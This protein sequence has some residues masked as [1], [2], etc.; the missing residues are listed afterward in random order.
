MKV[1]LKVVAN[2]SEPL[3]IPFGKGL[4]VKVRSKPVQGKANVEVVQLLAAHFKVDENQVKIVKGFTSSKKT[5]E[6]LL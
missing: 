1:E 6:I 2:S 3:V 5:V 4:K